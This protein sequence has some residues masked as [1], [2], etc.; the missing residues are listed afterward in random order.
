MLQ[1]LACQDHSEINYYYHFHSFLKCRLLFK[2]PLSSFDVLHWFNYNHL[3]LFI[4]L[5]KILILLYFMYAWNTSDYR[6]VCYNFI[7]LITVTVSS[8]FLEPRGCRYLVAEAI[9]LIV[10]TFPFLVLGSNASKLLTRGI[11]RRQYN[12]F[13]SIYLSQKEVS[14][15][16]YGFYGDCLFTLSCAICIHILGLP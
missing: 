4:L 6:F 9:H 11:H 10:Y 2:I 7:E 14:S 13:F 3:M 15:A 5:M 16:S 12:I 1:L 8:I